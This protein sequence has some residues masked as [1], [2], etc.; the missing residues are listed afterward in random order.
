[1]SLV[2]FLFVAIWTRKVANR[3]MYVMAAS[4]IPPFVGLLAL[5]LLPNEPQYKWTKW[6]MYFMTVPYVL[7][8]FLAWTLSTFEN[9]YPQ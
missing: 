2:I 5:A 3:R 6:G 1:M 9:P 8:L 4:C 7:A